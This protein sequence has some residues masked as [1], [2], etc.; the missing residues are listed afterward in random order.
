MTMRLTKLEH[1]CLMLERGGERL[2]I[3]PGTFTTPLTECANVAAV[4]VTHEHDDH[5]TK[6]QLA[7]ILDRSP[8]VHVISTAAV[9]DAVRALDLVPEAQLL[10]AKPG[11]RL[12]FQAFR[13]RFYGGEHAEIHSSIPRVDNLGVLVN[14]AFYYGG[15]AYLAPDDAAVDTL[16]VPAYGPWMRI[17]DTID[18][19]LEVR[20]RAV[21]GVHEMLLAR[22]GKELAA[23][24]IRAAAEEVG[25]AV[26]DLQ[27]YDTAEL[28][29]AALPDEAS[30]AAARERP[31]AAAARSALEVSARRSR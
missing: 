28:G 15:D 26:L 23:A 14:D 22:P 1:S 24:R 6:E 2:Y 4:V 27:P 12:E 7:R 9:I 17:A 5:W 16:A 11:D 13:L 29:D 18:Y 20:P 10:V 21:V 31:D 19:I 3:D 25:A 8:G 30:D